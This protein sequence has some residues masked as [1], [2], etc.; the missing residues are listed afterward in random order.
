M[1]RLEFAAALLLAV[2]ALAAPR[3]AKKAAARAP[4]PLSVADAEAEYR[5]AAKRLFA[6]PLEQEAFYAQVSGDPVL[7]AS[8]VT[9]LRQARAAGGGEAAVT[10][11]LKAA[12]DAETWQT[13]AVV[14]LTGARKTLQTGLAQKPPKTDYPETPLIGR[15]ATGL[16]KDPA[17]LF[18]ALDVPA[19]GGALPTKAGPA[20]LKPCPSAAT[21]FSQLKAQAGAAGSMDGGPCEQT[22]PAKSGP[23]AK[24]GPGGETARPTLSA[25]G[26]GVSDMRTTTGVP[27]APGADKGPGASSGGG[28]FTLDKPT[29]ARITLVGLFGAMFGAFLGPVGMVVGGAL[30][31]LA[32]AFLMKGGGSGGSEG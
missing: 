4:A 14:A 11:K 27:P 13:N 18:A 15:L 8:V 2:P 5:D 6:D 31:V 16:K 7:A 1:L 10:A 3:S 28:G 19:Y 20:A 17:G 21:A 32:G 9:A 30:G 24:A 23:P 25:S 26:P 12:P 29:V 22:P